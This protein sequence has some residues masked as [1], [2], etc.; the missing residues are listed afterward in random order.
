MLKEMPTRIYGLQMMDEV[1]AVL[2]PGNYMYRPPLSLIEDLE[3]HNLI[4]ISLVVGINGVLVQ[5][6]G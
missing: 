5:L 1:D 6:L 2:F 3:K 4:M